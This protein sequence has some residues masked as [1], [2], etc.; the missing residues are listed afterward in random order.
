VGKTFAV[1]TINHNFFV[2]KTIDLHVYF[3]FSNDCV[4]IVD[5]V[6]SLGGS[7]LNVDDLEI[8]V[9]YSGSQKCLSAPPGL[10]PISLSPRAW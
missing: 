3:C 5:S 1:Y 2:Y 4:L 10:S 8:D 7:P 6:A 9:V